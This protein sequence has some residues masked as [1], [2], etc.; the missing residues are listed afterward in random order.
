MQDRYLKGVLTE[1]ALNARKMAFISG[2]RQVGKTTLAKS[3]L[4][5]PRNYL[6]WD[7]TEFRRA[8]VRSPEQALE[9]VGK[10]PLILDEIHKDR[11]WKT[12]LKGVYDTHGDRLP[13]I[14]TGSAKLDVYRRGSDSLLGRYIPY[15][16][17]PFSVGETAAPPGP[18]Q[19]FAR[20]SNTFKWDDLLTLGGFPEPL[21]A[22]HKGK[23][24]RWSRLRLDRLAF[25]DTRDIKV[26]SDLNAFRILL[27][28]IPEK[29]GSLFSFNS[30]REDVGVAYATVRDWVLLSEILYFGFFVRPYSKGLKRSL[31]AEP[32]LYLYD[33]LQIPGSK[34]SARLENLTALHLLKACHYWTDSGQGLFELHFV[35][36]KEKREVDF[37]I[38]REKKPWML[39]ECKSND[40]NPSPHLAHFSQALKPE[41]CFQLVDRIGFD[42]EYRTQ[43]IRILNYE[44]FFAGWL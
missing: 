26:L 44:D 1:D 33:I 38:T 40:T 28:L 15:R 12:R 19:L 24:E 43:Q 14:V 23:A 36:D 22:G 34:R 7:Q 31:K 2:P 41:F 17:H 30:L 6:S 32:K 42:R 25:E 11:K 3:L 18:D 8:W 5:E 13:I 39:V 16:L 35:R 9:N 37:L 4:Q 10:G 27:D 21:L 20:R 29:V